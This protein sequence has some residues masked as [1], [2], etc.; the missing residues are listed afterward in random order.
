MNLHIK[1]SILV[2]L[3]VPA[4]L[5]AQQRRPVG[6]YIID[7]VAFPVKVQQT[8]DADSIV[9]II[10]NIIDAPATT[11]VDSFYFVPKNLHIINVDINKLNIQQ[12]E[13]ITEMS[14]DGNVIS[15]TKI[16]TS[17]DTNT[18]TIDKDKIVFNNYGAVSNYPIKKETK[19][20][21]KY[22]FHCSNASY[23]IIVDMHSCSIILNNVLYKVHKT[24]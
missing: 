9:G 7:S 12:P 6:E 11:N 17:S 24:N 5:F 23:P 16:T 10:K 20:N 1:A 8:I 4:L 22:V 19:E 15:K 2:I 18:I 14:F 21:E 3:F 13:T